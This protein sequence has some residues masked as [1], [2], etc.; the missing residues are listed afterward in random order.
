MD[1]APLVPDSLMSFL[2]ALGMLLFCLGAAGLGHFAFRRWT[3]ALDPAARIGVCGLLGLGLIGTGALFVGLVPG[4]AAFSR[5]PI[6]AAA[7]LWATRLGPLV[8]S[9]K[10]VWQSLLELSGWL[11]PYSESPS[12]S[13]PW[14][15]S[16]R[17]RRATGTRSLITWRYPSCTS[18]PDK[19]RGLASRAIRPSR[20]R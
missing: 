10:G 7:A 13:P 18:R 20:K 5:I 2:G 16:R 17:A 4:G 11:S 15:Y 9:I 19:S 14:F 8:K 3:E 6:L 12:S 1:T